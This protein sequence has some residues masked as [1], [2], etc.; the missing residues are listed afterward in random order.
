MKDACAYAHQLGMRTG[1]YL[2]PCQVPASVY[3]AHPESRGVEAI[4]YHGINMCPSRAWKTILAFDTYLLTYFGDS[5]DDVVVEMQDPGSCLCGECCRQFPDLVFRFIDSY[6]KLPGGPADRRI[7]LCTLH[8][9]NWLESPEG[10]TGVAFPIKDLR[11]R[12][13]DALP[14]G[15]SLFDVDEPTLEMGRKRQFKS[16]YFFFD[17]DPES[18]LENESVFPRVKLRRIESQIRQS[19]A[20]K[21]DGLVAYRM[22]PYTQYVADYA[23]LRKC[24]D[25]ALDLDVAMTELAA[26][27][28]VHPAERPIFVKAM[29]DLDAWWEDK[30]VIALNEADTLLHKLA[31]TPRCSGFLVD[32]KDLVAVLAIL[33]DF[34]SSHKNDVARKDFYPPA[35]LVEQ[36]YGMMRGRR[37][38]EAYT[39]HQHWEVRA[40][41]MIGQRLRWWLQRF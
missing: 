34:W 3:E 31:T 24:W 11:K 23:L 10:D 39:I 2:F 35:E 21:H 4:N 20:N 17:L 9:R 41:E 12:V 38:F 28:G 33:G 13:L 27:W 30:D 26:E 22:M 7:D 1:V 37:I 14:S 25:P 19:V 8:F 5:I 40:R 6:R 32:L 18:G 36:C 16:V 15:T 29:R